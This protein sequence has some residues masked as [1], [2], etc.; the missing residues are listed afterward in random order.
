MPANHDP[1][2]RD[3]APALP[4]APG[5]GSSA[6]SRWADAAAA[7]AC[8][9]LALVL[10]WFAAGHALSMDELWH[11]AMSAGRS[12]D[13]TGWPVDEVVVRPTS[14]TGLEHAAPPRAAWASFSEVLHPPLY[15]F[16]LRLWR[17]LC[18]G[19]DR[20]AAMY[21][22]ACGGVAILFVFLAVRMQAGLPLAASVA[23]AMAVS[24]VQIDLGTEVRSYALWMALS[25]C[26]A[27]QMVRMETRGATP[28]AVWALGLTLCPLMLT[29][30]FAAG[31]CLAA[32]IW[33]AIR[34]PPRARL[35]LL[36]AT[37]VA[38]AAAAVIWLPQ[39]IGQLA[40]LEAGDSYLKT[41]LPFWRRALPSGLALPL[42]LL[43][44]VPS[45]KLAVAGSA[46][47]VGLA[48]AGLRRRPA[49]L[50]WVLLLVVP[51][52]SILVLDAVRGTQNTVFLRYAA[53]AAVA[54]PAAT[55]LAAASLRPAAALAVGVAFVAVAAAGLGARRDI[56][57]PYYDHMLAPFVPVI[58]AAPREIPL[59][60]DARAG[61]HAKGAI[62]EFSHV[63]GFFPRPV[64][65]LARPRPEVM[66]PLRE[67][68]P[69]GRF[70][71]VTSGR[72][73]GPD[74]APD[75]LRAVDPALRIVRP[76]VVAAAGGWGV[77]PRPSLELWLVEFAEAEGPATGAAL[78]E[79]DPPPG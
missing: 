13:W 12:D 9:A 10:R 78:P 47:L 31:T 37:A 29:H 53:G 54:V 58:E 69:A 45:R 49:L 27:W 32:V 30:Y 55:V 75:W 28:P 61:L 59:V 24:P 60:C 79:A 77:C 56:G 65:L 11:L 62:L 76:P 5:P 16:T 68:A 43:V 34:L 2:D 25:A 57:S 42:R 14:L 36:A 48:V 23:L 1:P 33:G 67:A 74:P 66:R 26:A 4:A 46:V 3:R 44:Y 7:V 21:S 15:M 63:P 73:G 39:G 18:G 41:P 64:M 8:V 52:L 38:A 71:L 19:G 70:W 35:H 17:E 6:P 20:Q 22:A 51:I 72:G 50:P 40:D